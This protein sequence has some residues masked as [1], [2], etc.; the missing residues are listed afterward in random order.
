MTE[1]VA[2]TWGPGVGPGDGRRGTWRSSWSPDSVRLQAGPAASEQLSRGEVCS[3]QVGG[4]GVHRR[5]R[6]SLVVTCPHMAVEM[7][8][9]KRPSLR[10]GSWVHQPEGG[11]GEG[12]SEGDWECGGGPG[13]GLEGR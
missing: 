8:G 2:W 1:F 3:R 11:G 7:L 5:P 4:S 13:Q 10:A 12:R 6:R 9:V